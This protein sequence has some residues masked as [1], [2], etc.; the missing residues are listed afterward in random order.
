MHTGDPSTRKIRIQVYILLDKA[1]ATNDNE[2]L[3][4]LCGEIGFWIIHGKLYVRGESAI[5][6]M[7][8]RA[9]WES[10][11]FDEEPSL[12]RWKKDIIFWVEVVTKLDKDEFVEKFPTLLDWE[13]RDYVKRQY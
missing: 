4:K 2:E 8:I 12:P 7:I 1:Y 10:K 13:G 6:E 11:G 5:P 3:L 9:F